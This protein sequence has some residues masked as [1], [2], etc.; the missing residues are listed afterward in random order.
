M[1]AFH[2]KGGGVRVLESWGPGPGDPGS[3]MCRLSPSYV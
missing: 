3:R 2:L 1:L